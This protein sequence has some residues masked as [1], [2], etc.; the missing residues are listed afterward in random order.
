MAYIETPRTEAGDSTYMRN[1]YGLDDISTE[2]TFLSPF[3]KEPDLISQLHRRNGRGTGLE[4]PQLRA[5]FGDRRNRPVKPLQR[6]FTPLLGSVA[7]KSFQHSVKHNGAPETPAFLKNGYKGSD[8]PVLPTAT[9]GAYSENT[10]SS[11]GPIDEETPIAQ[12]TSS[13]AQFTPLP[14]LPKRGG[15]GVLTDQSNVHTLREQENIINKIDKENFGLKLKIH[16]LEE[17][18]RK[19]GPGLNEAALKENADLKVDKITIQKELA[20]AR[21]TLSTTEKEVEEYRNQ[22]QNAHDQ[23]K[24]KH[25][26]KKL[27]EELEILRREVATKDSKIQDLHDELNQGAAKDAEIEK[28]KSDIDDLE[29]DMREKDREL[30]DRED[31]LE[32]LKEKTRQ[33]S[34]ELAEAVRK[35]ESDKHRIQELEEHRRVSVEQAAR[36]HDIHDGM[37]NAQHQI[38]DL[39]RNVQ[40]AELEIK[41]ARREANEARLAKTK[42]EED[43]DE[44]RDE[45]SNKSF[46]TKGLN[47]QLEEKAQKLQTEL[48]ELRDESSRSEQEAK[49]RETR[50]EDKNENLRQRLETIDQKCLELTTQLQ[51]VTKSLQDKSEEKDL[52]HSLHDALTAQSQSLQKDLTRSQA[53]VQE[54]E[55]D[56]AAERS[57]ALKIDLQLRDEA[58]EEIRKLSEEAHSLQ[59]DLDDK[60]RQQAA[61]KDVWESQRRGLESE[62]DRASEQVAGLQRTIKTLQE[63]RGTLSGREQKLQEALESEKQRHESQEA[64]LKLDIEDLDADIGEKRKQL[65]DSK[66]EL[67]RINEELRVSKRTEAASEEQIEALEDE[68]HVLQ[69]SLDEEATRAKDDSA[70]ARQNAEALRHQLHSTKHELSRAENKLADVR[71]ELESYQNDLQAGQGSQ[72]H[73]NTRLQKLEADLQQ[74]KAERQSLQDELAKNNLEMHK[75]RS[76]L[77]DTEAERDEIKTQLKQAGMHA[78]KTFIRDEEKSELKRTKLRLES[79]VSQLREDR[80]AAREKIEAVEHELEVEIERASRE[81][82]RLNTEIAELNRRTGTASDSKDR[83][84]ITARQRIQS[85][86][87]QLQELENRAVPGQDNGQVNAELSLLQKDLSAVRKQET[88]SRQREKAQREVVR[89]L[90]S[91]VSRLE[92]QVHEAEIARLTVDSPKSSVGGSVRKTE[93]AELRSQLSDA[94]QQ[95]KDIRSKSRETEKELRRKLGEAEREAQVQMAASQQEHEQLEQEVSSL[96]QEQECEQSKLATAEK[97]ISRLRSRIQK[98]ESSLCEARGNTVGDRTMADERKDLHEMLKDAKIEAEDLQLQVATHESNLQSAASREKEL[99]AHLQR[100]RSERTHQ[101]KKSSA[102]V[103]ELDQLQSRYE[104]AIDNLDRHQKEWEAERQAMNSRVRFP[105]TSISEDKGN[106]EN[107]VKELQL[108]VAAKEKRHASEIKGMETQIQ[109]MWWNLEREADFRHCLKFEK[110]YLTTQVKMYE[111]CNQ[112][113]LAMFKKRLGI[114]AEKEFAHLERAKK[115]HLRTYAF[116][117]MFLVRAKRYAWEWREQRKVKGRLDEALERARKGQLIK[118]LE[119][120]GRG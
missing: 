99:R 95:L 28:L 112:L 62:R 25:A 116:M 53:K 13:S 16:F 45:M 88:S 109:W 27:L 107:A 85:L 58:R 59:R 90:K 66:A 47:R 78:D 52:L 19:S 20:R 42:V 98:L 15:D 96:R 7:K 65:A 54:L 30:N 118:K 105:N 46:S 32:D 33:E 5:P 14:S 63:T 11:L 43:L 22:L 48:V 83:E 55:A 91:K 38:Q 8:T 76:L 34:I 115:P 3:K 24:K 104:Q 113:D 111:A 82:S 77:D 51:Y 79:E 114:D 81:E 102:L 37:A 2:N 70:T 23:M 44:L 106:D 94:H 74:V 100:I 56:V 40:Q 72:D 26:D 50:L 9:P 110:S 4:T 75:I 68:I 84:L 60:E 21:K 57:H 86:Q 119:A 67:S 39:E 89:E 31:E 18:L 12:M 71:A 69:E 64:R 120:A 61:E 103:N 117:V 73:L 87:S 108:V 6:E 36:F 97:T 93:I 41:N 101:Q 1:G 29:F 10:G 80:D 92:R 35:V 17:S 49:R